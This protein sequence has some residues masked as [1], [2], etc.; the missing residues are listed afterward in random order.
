MSIGSVDNESNG[1]SQ[2]PSSIVKIVVG[3]MLAG[4]ALGFTRKL[5]KR[6]VEN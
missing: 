6:L 5:I 1:K 4:I 2:K 3:V